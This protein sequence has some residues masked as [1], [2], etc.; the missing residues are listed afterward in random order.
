MPYLRRTPRY[1]ALFTG[2]EPIVGQFERFL[3]TAMKKK[4]NARG[5]LRGE[6]F[7]TNNAAAG[8]ERF[9]QAVEL[10]SKL[11]IADEMKQYLKSFESDFANDW[12]AK[13]ALGLRLEVSRA[14]L[15]GRGVGENFLRK[16]V[17]S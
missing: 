5:H 8:K 14:Y 16:L 1:A 9:M 13:R 10:R 2:D 6:S 4:M 15:A 12:R 17:N 3:E 11:V 7:V